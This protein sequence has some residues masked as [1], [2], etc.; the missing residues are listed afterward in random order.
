MGVVWRWPHTLIWRRGWRKSRAIHLLPPQG[1]SRLF[2]GELYTIHAHNRN[3]GTAPLFRN[4]CAILCSSLG[5]EFLSIAVCTL[6]KQSPCWYSRYKYIGCSVALLMWQRNSASFSE[7]L[8][9]CNTSAGSPRTL[10]CTSVS[11]WQ[12]AC[13]LDGRYSD[14]C[15]V[16]SGLS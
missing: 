1:L 14:S 2:Q 15:T 9:E 7:S 12:P 10:E 11:P 8:A 3:T 13:L 5:R 4:L 16:E 6:N